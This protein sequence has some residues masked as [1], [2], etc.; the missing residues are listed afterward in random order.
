MLEG[1]AADAGWRTARIALLHYE[2]SAVYYSDFGL[3]LRLVH[4][5]TEVWH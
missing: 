4:L 3:T 1:V 2:R 5:K